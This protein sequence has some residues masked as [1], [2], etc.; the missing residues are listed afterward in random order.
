MITLKLLYIY[1]TYVW[2]YFNITMHF[3]LLMKHKNHIIHP[4]T[5]SSTETQQTDDIFNNT[6]IWFPYLPTRFS[7]SNIGNHKKL[8]A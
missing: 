5:N 8:S 2:N 6:Q 3:I 7:T 4:N 1:I